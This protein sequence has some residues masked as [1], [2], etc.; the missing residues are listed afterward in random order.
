MRADL[1][2]DRGL[3]IHQPERGGGAVVQE[4]GCRGD[5]RGRVQNDPD[6][7]GSGDGADGQARVVVGDGAPAHDHGVDEGA[8][9]MQVAAILFAGDIAGVSGAGGDEAVETLAE[10]SDG[11]GATGLHQRCVDLRELRARG[12]VAGEE[13][14]PG[15]VV[16]IG[17]AA[18]R[19]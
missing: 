3:G 16:G 19:R 5:A 9:A 11:E 12:L 18:A 17:G 15:A 4:N 8:Q 6:G 10:L 14:P 1:R 2:L 7:V 13:L